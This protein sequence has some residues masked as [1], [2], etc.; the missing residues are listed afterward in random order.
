MGTFDWQRDKDVKR[1]DIKQ[2]M[3]S[4]FISSGKIIY[5]N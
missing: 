2:E 4:Y 5:Q 1:E 3:I